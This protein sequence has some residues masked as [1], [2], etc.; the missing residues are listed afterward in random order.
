MACENAIKVKGKWRLVIYDYDDKTK[1]KTYYPD[2]CRDE[3]ATLLPEC[4]PEK[5]LV[6]YMRRIHDL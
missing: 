5:Q 4:I 1:T 3:Y 6:R 2:G